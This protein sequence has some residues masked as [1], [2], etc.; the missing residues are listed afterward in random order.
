MISLTF[1]VKTAVHSKWILIIIL[2]IFLGVLQWENFSLPFAKVPGRK[3]LSNLLEVPCSL[4]CYLVG[5]HW[6]VSKTI[7]LESSSGAVL[8]LWLWYTQYSSTVCQLISFGDNNFIGFCC[9]SGIS[10]GAIKWHP[11]ILVWVNSEIWNGAYCIVLDPN[12]STKGICKTAW[13]LSILL[14]EWHFLQFHP[15][16]K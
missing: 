10:G 5:F 14:C 6:I 15:S 8:P 1:F 11:L 7:D 4:W 9:K 16:L 13:V 2:F 3:S 12:S